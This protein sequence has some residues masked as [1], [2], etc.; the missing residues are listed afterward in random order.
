MTKCRLGPLLLLD[1]SLSRRL[2]HSLSHTTMPRATRPRGPYSLRLLPTNRSCVA[3]LFLLNLTIIA[4]WGTS[5]YGQKRPPAPV[6]RPPS[7]NSTAAAEAARER[8]NNIIQ[9]NSQAQEAIKE[10]G[11][12]LQEELRDS[13]AS[14]TDDSGQDSECLRTGGPAL[15]FMC[16]YPNWKCQMGVG[17]C[18]WDQGESYSSSGPSTSD[19]PY[20]SDSKDK[21]LPAMPVDP[22]EL[23]ERQRGRG[24]PICLGIRSS[25]CKV[26]IVWH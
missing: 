19:A 26:P 15:A 21:I 16:A 23:Q 10:A 2:E 13:S 1:C 11:D 24:P 25:F 22:A 3:V 8:A 14:G 12:K 17:P 7:S 4:G 5:C 9:N 20:I 6:V 18:N